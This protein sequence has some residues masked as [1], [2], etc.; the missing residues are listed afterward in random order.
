LELI[1]KTIC[2]FNFQGKYKNNGFD[3]SIL[4]EIYKFHSKDK[5]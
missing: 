3:N 4:I 1:S 2:L 5:L